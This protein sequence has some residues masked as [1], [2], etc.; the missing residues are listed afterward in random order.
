MSVKA[1]SRIGEERPSRRR[2]RAGIRRLVGRVRPP[3]RTHVAARRNG[4]RAVRE[5]AAGRVSPPRSPAR[6]AEPPQDS[7][8]AFRSSRWS[9]RSRSGEPASVQ[10]RTSA[11]LADLRR[12]D[13]CPHQARSGSQGGSCRR[14]TTRLSRF[15]AKS[16]RRGAG[17]HGVSSPIA[18]AVSGRWPYNR[19]VGTATGDRRGT[20]AVLARSA[21]REGEGPGP[22]RPVSRRTHAERSR[23]R[24]MAISS[25][26]RTAP[27][28][29][30]RLS[31]GTSRCSYLASAV[32]A[33]PRMQSRQP[34][35]H[36]GL[37]AL[38]ARTE[39]AK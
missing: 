33:S 24:T 25:D 18:E 13:H 32:S 27:S 9:G 3:A 1:P 8:R 17:A 15:P 38:V 6:E 19:R 31:C 39:A 21:A 20:A 29:A 10:L 23:P 14:V 4:Q 36:V 28:L 35:S 12:L 34:G 26:R 16:R 5:H 37:V 30:I 2:G 11:A 7:E 22:F